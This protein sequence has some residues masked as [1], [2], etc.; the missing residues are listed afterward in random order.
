[1]SNFITISICENDDHGRRANK[2]WRIDVEASGDNAI[3]FIDKT[4][5]KGVQCFTDS[6]RIVEIHGNRFKYSHSRD[7]VGNMKWNEYTFPP[8]YGLGLINLLIRSKEWDI[9]EGW[10]DIIE[11]IN[12]GELIT[13]KDLELDEDYHPLALHANQYEIPYFNQ[14]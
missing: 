9:E 2:A 4:L 7:W 8:D 6:G 14:Q 11:K 12:R 13:G 5:F 3:A 1:M 10:T